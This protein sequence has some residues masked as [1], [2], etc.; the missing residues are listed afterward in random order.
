MAIIT[1][2]IILVMFINISFGISKITSPSPYHHR[3]NVKDT[4]YR[5]LEFDDL[6]QEIQHCYV[7]L[8]IHLSAGFKIEFDPIK[9][10]I[11]LYYTHSRLPNNKHP[12]QYSPEL[13][14]QRTCQCR[15][16]MLVTMETEFI[17]PS[18][19]NGSD[20]TRK[21]L[22]TRGFVTCGPNTSW[23]CIIL[24]SYI[25]LISLSNQI[26][27]LEIPSPGRTNIFRTILKC[28]LFHM[29]P[30]TEKKF[31]QRASSFD[32]QVT[33]AQLEW[34]AVRTEIRNASHLKPTSKYT[35]SFR[36]VLEAEKKLWISSKSGKI[37]DRREGK[38]VNLVTQ[39]RNLHHLTNLS[40][41]Q[42][43]KSKRPYALKMLMNVVLMEEI[44]FYT[45]VND[46]NP[47]VSSARMFESLTLALL[48][49][50]SVVK[51]D[52]KE[53][54]IGQH[55]RHGLLS[56]NFATCVVA[57]TRITFE[58]YVTPFQ[59]PVWYFLLSTLLIIP[60]ILYL[61]HV[62][63]IPK[64][65]RGIRKW[66]FVYNIS[67]ITI[68]SLLETSPDPNHQNIAHP[69][70]KRTYRILIGTW[71]II[72]ILVAAIYRNE[73][74]VNMIAP[75][76]SGTN[77]T[78]FSQLDSFHFYSPG[79]FL[80]SLDVFRHKEDIFFPFSSFHECIKEPK[81]TKKL[82]DIY[83]N[84]KVINFSCLNLT[85]FLV[86]LG[87]PS[88]LF[89]NQG[90]EH[91]YFVKVH[92]NAGS[93]F[94]HDFML[95]LY[96]GYWFPVRHTYESLSTCQ[97]K[98]IIAEAEIL[99]TFI[100]YTKLKNP[101]IIFREGKESIYQLPKIYYFIGWN[102]EYFYSRMQHLMQSGIHDII[103]KVHNHYY[104]NPWEI[105]LR[106]LKNSTT[107]RSTPSDGALSLQT[108]I[109]TLFIIYGAGIA[110]TVTSLFLEICC[111]G[112]VDAK[113]KKICRRAHLVFQFIKAA[114]QMI[115]VTMNMCIYTFNLLKSTL[116]C[117]KIIRFATVKERSKK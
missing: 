9:V 66:G 59:P 63:K 8:T 77:F 17:V 90:V 11:S 68:G 29:E 52:K 20:R 85:S 18:V 117:V 110:A 98:G 41:L 10:P 16:I 113:L 33:G 95:T 116:P 44:E 23:P 115:T 53:L 4:P 76:P 89:R 94:H 78:K 93:A 54:F 100:E 81:S 71:S 46:R 64:S 97:R 82:D 108:S 21:W 45:T 51:Y 109:V 56:F 32:F 70:I 114:K 80:R 83:F 67:S 102:S 101:N 106:K 27:H 79:L 60:F 57:K 25:F 58:M 55:L 30:R 26:P 103:H 72:A 39:F 31:A 13:V 2:L 62:W 38:E 6:L 50:A 86:Q 24:P 61:V 37:Y 42:I 99:E 28:I 75:I 22:P 49:R 111:K 35:F 84:G 47:R 14:R 65:E 87:L 73:L 88:S 1:N 19:F 91:S 96:A 12:G 36:K 3:K 48:E 104:P 107:M 40:P 105:E 7:S 15:V 74:V 5:V 69:T 34:N 92:V 43:W 112:K